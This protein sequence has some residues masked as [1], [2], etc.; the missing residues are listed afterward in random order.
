MM[1]AELTVPYLSATAWAW[2][3]TVP[4]THKLV[5]LALATE[6]DEHGLVETT[7]DAVSSLT[8]MTGPAVGATVAELQA[9]GLIVSHRSTVGH[10]IVTLRVNQQLQWSEGVNSGSRDNA[11]AG[12]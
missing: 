12:H 3:A 4:S 2:E 7:F 11:A 10:I 9:S 8:G 5:L 6:C 1:P